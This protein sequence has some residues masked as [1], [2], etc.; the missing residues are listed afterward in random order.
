MQ[1]GR[2]GGH[3]HET[4]DL[5]PTA[6]RTWRRPAGHHGLRKS[7]V[8][9]RVVALVKHEARAGVRTATEQAVPSTRPGAPGGTRTLVVECVWFGSTGTMRSYR[10]SS[11]SR[12]AR[13]PP[14]RRERLWARELDVAQVVGA[15]IAQRRSVARLTVV[16]LAQRASIPMKAVAAAER[17]DAVLTL[18]ALV[19]VAGAFGVHAAELV[20]S[21]GPVAYE[22]TPLEPT[23]RWGPTVCDGTQVPSSDAR[24]AVGAALRAL[25]RTRRPLS[26]VARDAGMTYSAAARIEQGRTNPDI[27]TLAHL[28]DAC[29]VELPSLLE[30]AGV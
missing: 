16:E 15:A 1:Q 14:A 6:R 4:V 8:I 20:A 12:Y 18:D 22:R 2:K 13:L 9:R 10:S 30:R 17:G 19:A 25:R 11:P 27:V 28:V 5:D 24:G 21:V 26:L 29:G 23:S 3:W 7:V